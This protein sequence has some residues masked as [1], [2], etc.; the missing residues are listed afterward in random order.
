MRRMI[1]SFLIGCSFSVGQAGYENDGL[2][3]AGV[4]EGYVECRSGL[5][6]VDGGG[7][8]IIEMWRYSHLKVLSTSPFIAGYG[9]IWDIRLYGHMDYFG[10]QTEELSIRGYATASLYGGR[11]DYIS[12]YQ[13]V[14]DVFVGY[15]EQGEPIFDKFRHIEMFVKSY[16]YNPTTTTL[17]GTWADNSTFA[18]KLLNQAGYDPVIDNIKFI[19]V[20]EPSALMLLGL[21]GLLLSRRRTYARSE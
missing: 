10:G 2:I 4:Y 21:G 7:A 19:L 18:I 12:S 8:D 6:V 16:L 3:P 20:P 13:T 1:L 11:I 17:T 14:P 9:G 15:N 5:L